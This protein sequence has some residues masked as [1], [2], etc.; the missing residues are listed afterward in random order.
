VNKQFIDVIAPRLTFLGGRSIE[1]GSRLA[2]LGL[3]SMHAIDLLFDLEDS[4][5][6]TLGDDELNA[7][8]FATAGSLWDAVVRAA[9]A[10]GITIQETAA[11]A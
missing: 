6:V 7:T 1:P 10:D 2:D 8:T 11:T 5:G 9:E 4:F 3:D